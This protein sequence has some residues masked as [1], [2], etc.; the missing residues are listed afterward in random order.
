ADR[1]ADVQHDDWDRLRRLFCREGGQIARG[2]DQVHLQPD[3][4]RC[5]LDVALL[6]ALPEPPINE[7]VLAFDEAVLS[8]SVHESFSSQLCWDARVIP[9]KADAID[10]SC[11]LRARN[12][13]PRRRAAQQRDDLAP[14]HSMTSSARPSMEIGKVM[15]SALAVFRLRTS[16]TFVDCSTGRSPGFSPLRMRP[17]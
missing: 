8:Q 13:G 12:E 14:I 10:F 1:I 6:D 4:C 3:Q 17:T 2:H 16:S 5:K 11:L 9:Q 7:D 15:P